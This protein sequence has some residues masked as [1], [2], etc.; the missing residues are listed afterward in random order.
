MENSGNRFEKALF[1]EL[2]AAGK[3]N[4]YALQARREGLS[5]YADIF[6]ELAGNE[7]AHAQQI[8][9]LIFNENTTSDNLKIAI[10]GEKFEYEKLYPELSQLAVKDGNL[11]A[12]R[13]FKQIGKIEE[14]HKKRLS[15]MLELLEN[16]MVYERAVPT[17]WKCDICG[18]EFDGKKPPERC[19]ACTASKDHYFPQDLKV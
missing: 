19:P 16:D 13:I 5:Y 15:K 12:A 2:A 9:K 8:N 11:E 1:G 4:L 18:Y 7:L 10:N 14:H 6:D 17:R 3:Y